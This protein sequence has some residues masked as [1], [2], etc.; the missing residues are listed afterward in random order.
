MD[1]EEEKLVQALKIVEDNMLDE[2]YGDPNLDSPIEFSEKFIKA[3]EHLIKKQRNPIRNF[4]HSSK[5]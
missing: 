1:S 3:M 4:F 5:K 2:I